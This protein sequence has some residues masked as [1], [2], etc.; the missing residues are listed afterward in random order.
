MAVIKKDISIENDDV[1]IA[2]V[3]QLLPPI[4]LL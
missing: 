1:R 3:E 2:K 4:T